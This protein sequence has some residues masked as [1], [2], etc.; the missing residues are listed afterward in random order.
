[1]GPNVVLLAV[2]AGMQRPEFEHRVLDLRALPPNLGYIYHTEYH[3]GR[4]LSRQMR[5]FL[6]ST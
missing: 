5:L 2:T 6:V 1:M 4:T 3:G